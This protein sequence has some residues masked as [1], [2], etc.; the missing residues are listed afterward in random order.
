MAP[1][2]GRPG[3]FGSLGGLRPQGAST[4]QAYRGCG[5]FCKGRWPAAYR[6][7][8]RDPIQAKQP[9]HTML[10]KAR[11]FTGFADAVAAALFCVVDR[12]TGGGG[13][14]PRAR[15]LL[16]LPLDM[17]DE[18]NGAEPPL[19]EVL[20]G[21]RHTFQPLA[22]PPRRLRRRRGQSRRLAIER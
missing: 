22:S 14:A 12:D 9:A 8:A 13:N 18:C 19:A 10:E 17:A 20:A 5:C 11:A 2:A 16:E 4:T 6:Q 7:A 3:Y 1:A 15:S 21:A